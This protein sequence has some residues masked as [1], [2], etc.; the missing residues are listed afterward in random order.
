MATPGNRTRGRRGP[1]RPQPQPVEI[2]EVES[3]LF[4]LGSDEEPAVVDPALTDQEEENAE[5]KTAHSPKGKGEEAAQFHHQPVVDGDIEYDVP[6]EVAKKMPKNSTVGIK[7]ITKAKHREAVAILKSHLVR[8]EFLTPAHAQALAEKWVLD[9]EDLPGFKKA[10]A[11]LA[12]ESVSPPYKAVRRDLEQ[13]AV[14]RLPEVQ[15]VRERLIE[16][17]SGGRIPNRGQVA[18]AIFYTTFNG[19]QPCMSDAREKF[20]A[21]YPLTQH[22]YG[23]PEVTLDLNSYYAAQRAMFERQPAVLAMAANLELFRQLCEL[24]KPSGKPRFP[25]AGRIGFIDGTAVEGDVRQ[26]MSKHTE[27]KDI[28]LGEGR[29]L[30]GQG[31]YLNE[32][33]T[34]RKKWVG[35]KLVILGCQATTLPMVWGLCHPATQER[36]MA[37][38]LVKMLFDLWPEAP[39]EALVGDSHYD[40]SSDFA[41]ELVFNYG[42]QPIFNQHGH[43]SPNRWT[44]VDPDDEEHPGKL[45][46][47]ICKHGLM[48][49]DH[50][51]GPLTRAARA[52]KGLAPGDQAPKTIRLRWRCPHGKKVDGKKPAGSCPGKDTYP[53]D[54]PRIYTYYPRAGRHS[55]RIEREVL[56]TRR[57]G[58]ESINSLVQWRGLAGRQQQRARKATDKRVDW[59]LS[60]G[61]TYLT[62][63]RLTH[64]RGDYKAFYEECETLGYLEPATP[65][66]P[67][68]GPDADTY[69]QVMAEVEA[70]GPKVRAP[71]DVDI[72]YELYY[73]HR[74]E[75]VLWGSDD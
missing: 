73:T 36:D 61:L 3:G 47:P 38:M 44:Y 74:G 7:E 5:A 56:L 65:E 9:R 30:I 23:M 72:D 37:L 67:A 60:V 71:R 15:W 35:Y 50:V 54:N 14:C 17:A 33:G 12:P 70:K 6:L 57:N 8:T 26:F 22:C 40:L 63:R 11:K 51:D 24:E 18:D 2:S 59:L 1:R 10:W 34:V 21:A 64:E 75:R 20:T 31:L 41:R 25:N 13:G 55:R 29:D 52:K 28:Y 62:A 42:V 48:E 58:I 46:V 27:I 49:L 69:Q 4:W 32:D 66:A 45:G 68:P 53:W 43:Y 39:L 19:R 16:R